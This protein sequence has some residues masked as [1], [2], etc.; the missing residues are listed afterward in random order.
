[1]TPPRAAQGRQNPLSGALR[2]PLTE[3]DHSEDAAWPRRCE[4]GCMWSDLGNPR[5][6]QY[7]PYWCL[8]CI[9]AYTSWREVARGWLSLAAP[10]FQNRGWRVRELPQGR[11]TWTL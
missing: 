8:T 5:S 7:A 2:F 6:R 9:R 11:R 4:W 10:A 1:M 3:T